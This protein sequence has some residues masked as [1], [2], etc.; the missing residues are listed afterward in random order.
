MIRFSR[1]WREPK[2]LTAET[3]LKRE[4]K[5]YLGIKGWFV[6]HIIQGMGSFDGIPDL[7]ATKNGVTV[8]IETKAPKGV[9]S[10]R[11]KDYQRQLELHGGK[12]LLVKS[13]E[14]LVKE[15]L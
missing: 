2:K 14:D 12:Y 3:L 4:C 11:Q 13:V 1:T 5:R 7:L 8:E 10:D 15:G 6:R 9:Q